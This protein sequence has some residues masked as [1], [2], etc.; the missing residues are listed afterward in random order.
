MEI[1]YRVYN[2]KDLKDIT[3][4]FQW[5]ITPEG[6]LCYIEYD[7]VPEATSFAHYELMIKRNNTWERA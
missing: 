6:K 2:N 3:H 4:E 7:D 1:R 5:V